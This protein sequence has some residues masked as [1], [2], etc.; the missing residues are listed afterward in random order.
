[1]EKSVNG[2]TGRIYVWWSKTPSVWLK[3]P[4]ITLQ[5]TSFR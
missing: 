4:L 1:M 3:E 2:V 5:Y